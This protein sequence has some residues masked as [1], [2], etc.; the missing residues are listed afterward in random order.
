L[1]LASVPAW[2]AHPSYLDGKSLADDLNA[3][4]ASFALTMTDPNGDH[5]GF[6]L[7]AL[8]ANDVFV[9]FWGSPM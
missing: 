9:C 6:G 1:L 2:N 5:G 8:D 7:Y 3:L 4:K